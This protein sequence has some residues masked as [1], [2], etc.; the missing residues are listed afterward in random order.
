MSSNS[1]DLRKKVILNHLWTEP[2][3]G[4]GVEPGATKVGD[5]VVGVVVDEEPVGG[6]EDGVLEET[7]VSALAFQVFKVL[8]GERL[9]LAYVEK[10]NN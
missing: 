6:G 1:D 10:S 8:V 4:A 3:D 5:D 9:H 2:L 7:A